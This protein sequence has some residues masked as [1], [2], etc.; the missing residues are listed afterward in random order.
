MWRHSEKQW[1]NADLST[2]EGQMQHTS[3][4]KICYTCKLV[5]SILKVWRDRRGPYAEAKEGLKNS[6]V[7]TELEGTLKSH[8]HRNGYSST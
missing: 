8:P 7:C 2:D 4:H 3:A 5:L 1:T 6:H